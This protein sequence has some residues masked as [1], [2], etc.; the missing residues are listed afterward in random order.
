MKITHVV[1][2]TNFAGV[3][4]HVAILAAAQ[5]DQGHEVTVLGGDQRR[6]RASIDRAGVMLCPAPGLR[7]ALRCLAG[8]AGRGADVV[9]THMTTADVA[10]L[11]SPALAQ[12]PVVSTRH[13]AAPRGASPRA[14]SVA[15]R[16]QSRLSAEIAVSEYIAGGL[17]VDSTVIHPGIAD[18]PDALSPS[19]RDHTVLVAQRLEEEKATDIAVAAFA[20]SGLAAQGWRLVVA[21]DG[22]MRE[23]LQLLAERL[24]IGPS[25]DFLGHRDDVAHLMSAAAITLAPC[26]IEGFGLAVVEAMASSTPVVAAAAGGHLESVGGV[27]DA[28]LFPPGDVRAAGRLLAELADDAERR[29]RYGR[30]LRDR[31]RE[32]FSISA[33]AAT[34]DEVYRHAVESRRGDLPLAPG[35]GII[36]ISLEPWDRV[37]RRN[38]HL[39]A[40]LLRDDPTLRVLV[41][42]PGTDPLHDL[43]SGRPTRRGKG[44][45]RGPLLPGVDP[46]NLWLL[47]PTKL[48]PRRLDPRQDERW[49]DA[50]RLAAAKL[51]L[52]HPA[53]WVNDPQGALVMQRTGWSTLYDITDDWLEAKRG[54]ET[55]T[56]L[57][58]HEDA[59]M[60]QA[61]AV[62]VCSPQLVRTKSG[63]RPVT[64]IANAVDGET[65]RPTAR[66]DD[67]PV[68]PVAVYVGT[69][70]ADRLDV[71]LCVA[72]AHAIAAAGTVV[73]VGPDALS[74][75]DRDRLA[76]AGVVRLGSKDRRA[77]P[78]YLQH[79]DVLLVPHVVD[80]FTDSLDPIK[81][82][83]YRAVGRPVVS[84][85]V[86]GF[87]DSTDER[88]T[89]T[90][91]AGFPAAVAAAIPATYQYPKG[92]DPQVPTWGDRVRE[93]RKVV[94]RVLVPVMV[95][96]TDDTQSSVP[97]KVRVQLGHAAVQHIAG[98]QGIDLL[99]IKGS[100]LDPRLASPGRYS[101]DADVLVRPDHI[102][103]L[104]AA[105]ALAGYRTQARFP[106]SSP[107]EHSTTLWHHLWGY[108]DVHRHYPGIGLPP[109]V[110][111]DRL[112]SERATRQICGIDCPTPSLAAQVAILVMHAGRNPPGGQSDGD[113]AHAWRGA[114]E[115]LQ[116]SVGR[117][118][119]EFKAQVAFAAGTGQLEQ[120]PPSP[121]R[122]LWSAVTRPG[123]LHEWR[124]RIAAAP[125]L[126]SRAVLVA[127]SPLVNTD[128]LATRLG[129]HPSRRDIAVEF[130]DRL[131]RALDELTGRP[132]P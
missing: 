121:E 62:V 48:L 66:P 126:R 78:A 1:C 123:R 20:A 83:E 127:R 71:D 85:P 119:D 16:L 54:P 14:R 36:V 15:E 2:T 125:N 81:L 63:R 60:D 112:W 35:N 43:R 51:R 95:S 118:V 52:E 105:C 10:A 131:R 94:D 68:G 73:L 77:V 27:D 90:G 6:M 65:T 56:R 8:P 132:R 49:A 18:R 120:L 25:T 122:E 86:A 31:Q 72:T 111:F 88:I 89:V 26:P 24:A 117:W 29:D 70:H 80:S 91:Q 106:T 103:R 61:A 40:G 47:E 79:A 45:R 124:A 58:R 41:V 87:R 67:L 22:A 46:D 97:L 98:Q 104:L 93:I 4:R 84:T 30:A 99:H 92:S 33:Q 5:H 23:D 96:P 55:L 115:D 19:R 108:V 17:D 102:E 129:R 9:A 74:P 50:V 130:V 116:Q 53:L 110:A 37:W 13:F 34:T 100:A 76:A 44:L 69:L 128:H 11:I 57:R 75:P 3:E 21:G 28:A 107:F 101:T 64:L 82:Y 59:L 113:V 39:L 38:Q 42:E 12:T 32:H 109:D 114:D 7:A